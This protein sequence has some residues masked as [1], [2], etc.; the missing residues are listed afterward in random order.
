MDLRA[1]LG[2]DDPFAANGGGKNG[3]NRISGRSG[4]GIERGDDSG[5]K[6]DAFREGRGRSLAG[7]R[8]L[9]FSTRPFIDVV[10]YRERASVFMAPGIRSR[11]GCLSSITAED[12][13]ICFA[14]NKQCAAMDRRSLLLNVADGFESAG[15]RRQFRGIDHQMADVGLLRME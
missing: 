2:K 11:V 1:S 3:V 9:E 15:T 10:S 5:G 14:R 12:E 13:E 6:S 7:R 8:R 4:I